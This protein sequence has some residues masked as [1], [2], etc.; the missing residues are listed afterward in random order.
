MPAKTYTFNQEIYSMAIISQVADSEGDAI[1]LG[2]SGG[3]GKIQIQTLLQHT[4]KFVLKLSRI[5]YKLTY[6]FT[7]QSQFRKS[8]NECKL[9]LAKG[10]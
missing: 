2:C 6:F 3:Q 4:T 5:L 10:L 9:L 1:K 7:K 8:L